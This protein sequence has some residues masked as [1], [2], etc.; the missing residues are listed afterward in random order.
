MTGKD[1]KMRG[2]GILKSALINL[3]L[4]SAL[5]GSVAC[6]GV[7]QE[8]FDTVSENL[9]TALAREQ[10]V[11]TDLAVSQS[12]FEDIEI[13]LAIVQSKTKDIK[14]ELAVA[15]SKAKD[16]ET[17]LD[18]ARANLLEY[19]NSVDTDYADLSHRAEQAR[20]ILS[21]FNEFVHI[22]ITGD[23]SKLVQL[24]GQL[25]EVENT[26]IQESLEYLLEN[27]DF[28]SEDETGMIVMSWLIEAEKLLGK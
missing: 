26:D 10:R 5:F 27:S 16:I 14:T 9:D 24:F 28:I 4:L 2:Y 7:S 1:H 17:E 25:A 19:S 11:E 20:L 23:T 3:I 15:R 12:K 22:G 8:E 21:I 18:D 13:E 6:S